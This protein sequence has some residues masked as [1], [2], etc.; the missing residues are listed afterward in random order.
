M[1]HKLTPCVLIVAALGACGGSDAPTSAVGWVMPNNVAAKYAGTWVSTCHT[2]GDSIYHYKESITLKRTGET[3]LSYEGSVVTY[4]DP[5][6]SDASVDVAD[7]TGVLSV[8]GTAN[9]GGTAVDQVS[10]TPEDQEAIKNIL[11]VQAGVLRVGQRDAPVTAVGFPSS[12][13]ASYSLALS[14]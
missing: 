2:D 8:S 14:H 12:L 11:A 6:C 5:A 13:D 3:T 9:V 10:V 7:Y 4:A 1:L